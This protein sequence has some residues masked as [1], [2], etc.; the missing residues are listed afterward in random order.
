[1]S[2]DFSTSRAQAID[3]PSVRAALD[4]QGWAILPKLLTGAECAAVAGLYG[5]DECFRSRV[6]MTRHGYGRGEYRYFAYPLPPIVEG[7]RTVLYPHLAPIANI[8]HERL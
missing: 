7:M 3:W 2:E 6:I 8:W 4:A 5:R 1:M